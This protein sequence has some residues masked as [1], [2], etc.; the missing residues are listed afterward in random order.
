MAI[1]PVHRQSRNDQRHAALLG[2]APSTAHQLGRVRIDHG[3]QVGGW[4]EVDVNEED[5]V[6]DICTQPKFR[7]LS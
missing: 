1:A 6:C 3:R 5:V 2:R 4:D 7:L